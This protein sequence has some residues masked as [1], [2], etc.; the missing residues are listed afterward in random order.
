M[1]KK[2]RKKL[3]V[4]E[5]GEDLWKYM[6]PHKSRFKNGDEFEGHFDKNHV[7]QLISGVASVTF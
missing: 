6:E 2:R 5:K 4:R 1:G 3:L 7:T